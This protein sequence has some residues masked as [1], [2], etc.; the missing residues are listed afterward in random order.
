METERVR[1]FSILCGS[2][3]VSNDS[4]DPMRQFF[5]KQTEKVPRLRHSDSLVTQRKRLTG[6]GKLNRCQETEHTTSSAGSAGK[7]HSQVEGKK[8]FLGVGKAHTSHSQSLTGALGSGGVVT[9]LRCVEKG[10]HTQVGRGHPRV[11]GWEARLWVDKG[12][13]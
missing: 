7:R 5:N 12:Y 10:T 6:R 1:L 3:S 9:M 13:D 8:V 11:L 4:L 2:M